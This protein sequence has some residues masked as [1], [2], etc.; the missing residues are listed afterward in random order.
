MSGT[1]AALLARVDALIAKGQAVAATETHRERGNAYVEW[2]AHQ[3][4]RTQSLSALAAI[5]GADHAY[6]VEFARIVTS[7]SPSTV[8]G[9]MGILRALREDIANG[10]L[11]KLEA[12]VS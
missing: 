10:Y 3:E 7:N 2:G 4:W 5:V 9:G 12:L 1:D 11:R 6:R 8:K